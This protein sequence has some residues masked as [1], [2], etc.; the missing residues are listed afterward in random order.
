MCYNMICLSF[1]L[2]GF[3]LL[4]IAFLFEHTTHRSEKLSGQFQFLF[5]R[6]LCIKAFKRLR[7]LLRD[8]VSLRRRVYSPD[9]V[10]ISGAQFF[11]QEKGSISIFRQ[12]MVA[13][14]KFAGTG[15]AAFSIEVDVSLEA[16]RA[17]TKSRSVI[18]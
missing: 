4:V 14:T 18:Q 7:F 8:K 16:H 12:V 2:S 5:W 6:E 9:A 1:L 11:A 3:A 10:Q 15:K 13:N 17:T